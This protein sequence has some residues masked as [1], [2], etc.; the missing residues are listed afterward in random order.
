VVEKET[1]RESNGKLN[2]RF[3]GELDLGFLSEYEVKTFSAHTHLS[4]RPENLFFRNIIF[5]QHIKLLPPQKPLHL[6]Q[7]S[8][9]RSISPA[10]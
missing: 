4:P 5:L 9:P 3:K 10:S 2:A 1:R 8:T 7:L 6:L